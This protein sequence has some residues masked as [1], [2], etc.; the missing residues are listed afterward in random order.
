M[1]PASSSAGAWY[2]RL[3]PVAP[4]VETM[5]R[6]DDPRLGECAVFWSGAT[7]LVFERNQPVLVGF[8][9]DEGVRRNGG[10]VGAAAAPGEI[11]RRLYGLTPWDGAH[12]VDLRPLELLDLGDVLV[13]SD[14]EASQALLGEVVAAVL[15]QGAIPIVL[16]GG[17]ETA[18]GHYLGYV[19]LRRL[20][21]VINLDAH[22]DV[23]PCLDGRGHSG[24][25]FRQALE[26]SDQPLPGSRYVCLGA[27]P[28]SVS[29]VHAEYVRQRRGVIGW[30][31]DVRG[32]LHAHLAKHIN[33]AAANG[34]QAYVSVDCDV[35]CAADMPGVSAPSPLG[36]SAGE[37]CASARL[38][39]ASPNV[40]SFDVV[41]V[42]PSLDRDGQSASC[43][44][45]I[46]WHFLAGLAGRETHATKVSHRS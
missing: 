28:P 12:D 20:A 30:V 24:S 31:E 6:P 22:L 39:G 44:A 10:R 17:H 15:A 27:Q 25:P 21:T 2:T 1:S 29:R 40:T 33:G 43:G 23:R 46:V 14:L 9:Q 45:L 26:H 34:W 18:Y 37:V 5:R 19:Q 8:P 42:N 3:E 13:S 4:P 16:G 32:S 36:L 7:P 38:A 11:R 41:E 35:I